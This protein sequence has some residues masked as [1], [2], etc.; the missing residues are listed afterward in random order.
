M[1]AIIQTRYGGPD[2]L[3]LREVDPPEIADDEVLVHMRAASVHPDIWH[4]MR[5]SPYMLRVMGAGVRRPKN[6]VPGT[7]VAGVVAFLA[8]PDAAYVS[9]QVIYVSGAP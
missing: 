8:G 2:V 3:V 1:K 6:P 9:G 4:V 5:G 7:D